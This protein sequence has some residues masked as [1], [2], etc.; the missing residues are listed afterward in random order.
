MTKMLP[1]LKNS[2]DKNLSTIILAGGKGSRLGQEKSS[3]I[4]G[5]KSLISHVVDLVLPLNTEIIVV[6]SQSQ[7]NIEPNLNARVVKDI[8]A[9]KGALGG[10]YTGLVTSTTPY[11]IIVACDMPFLKLD[12]L[13][14][15]VKVAEGYDIAI[16]RVD[17][18][19][20][21]LHAIYSRN[22]IKTIE[23]MFS[24][25][26]LRVSNLLQRVNVRYI[27]EQEF[28]IYDPEHLSFF[29][30]NNK[31]DLDKAKKMKEGVL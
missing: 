4:F 11:S 20:E 12:L 15:M 9:D 2:M 22:C 18:N 13:K 5:K 26:E 21:P 28:N 14:Y 25:G 29:N 19:V 24:E 1:H 3:L 6:F 23:R 16:P 30:I 8:F 31:N 7:K 10:V 27:D 17:N